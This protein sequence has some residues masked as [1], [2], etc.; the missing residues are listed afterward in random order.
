MYKEVGKNSEDSYKNGTRAEWPNLRRK[1][2]ENKIPILQ[3]RRK[4]LITKYK[5]VTNME[6]IETRPGVDDR[7]WNKTFK[8][9][10]EVSV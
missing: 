3:N 9:D 7:K 8:E 2:E 6:K 1:N 10:H 5:I 4:D